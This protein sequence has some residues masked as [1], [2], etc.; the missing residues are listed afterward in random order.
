L[1]TTAAFLTAAQA[2]VYAIGSFLILEVGYLTIARAYPIQRL[3]DQTVLLASDAILALCYFLPYFI[4]VPAWFVTVSRFL[5]VAV[6]LV[7]G[8]RLLIGLLYPKKV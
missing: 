8:L 3:A 4:L 6:L 7:L 2:F 5:F 1:S